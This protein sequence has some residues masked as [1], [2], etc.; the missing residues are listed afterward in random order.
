MSAYIYT[1]VCSNATAREPREHAA[2][3]ASFKLKKNDISNFLLPLL[4]PTL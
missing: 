1:P 2:T 4:F 3:T